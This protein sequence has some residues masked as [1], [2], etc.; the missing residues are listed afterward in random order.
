VA[1]TLRRLPSEWSEQSSPGELA[2]YMNLAAQNSR[3]R[4]TPK[5]PFVSS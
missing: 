3:L 2:A 1:E 5:T 4:E